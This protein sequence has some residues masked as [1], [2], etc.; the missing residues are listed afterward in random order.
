MRIGRKYK[1]LK[2]LIR[3]KIFGFLNREYVI[4]HG[5][6]RV[7]AGVAV[8][9]F[10]F[11]RGKL[12]IEL[13]T[14]SRL[15]ENIIIQGSGKLV[16]G[17]NSFIGDYSIV[18]CNEYIR[19][20]NN[21]MISQFVSIRDTDHKFDRLDVP[22]NVQGIATAPV[23]IEDD[24]WIGHGAVITK[25]VT[26]GQGAIVGAN[27]VVTKDVPPLAVMGGVPARVIKYRGAENA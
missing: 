2:D 20:G 14:H 13:K 16:L 7:N 11:G 10:D 22:M 1:K 12:R 19:I 27:A 5:D 6:A 9:P 24:V 8:K 23:H 17:E 18:G 25:G 26:I 15:N 4:L 3:T 21:V